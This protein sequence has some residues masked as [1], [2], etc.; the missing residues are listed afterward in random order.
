MKITRW[1]SWVLAAMTAAV[2][3]GLGGCGSASARPVEPRVVTITAVDNAFEA[4]AQVPAGL[5]TIRLVNRGQ[6]LHHVQM[7]KLDEGKTLADFMAALQAGGPPPAWAKDVGG[8]N[9]P[10]PGG[11]E[12]NATLNLAPG[13]YVL[14][15]FIDMPGGVPHVMKGMI[16]GLT[17]TPSDA[18]AAEPTGDVTMRLTDYAFGLS[19]PLAAGKQTIVVENGAAQPH[20]VFI[21]QL[22]PG[23]TLEDLMTW[24]REPN[25]PPPASAVG[26][27]TGIAPGAKN[28]IDVDLAPGSYVLLCFVPDAGDGKPHVQHGMMQTIEVK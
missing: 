27:V 14:L 4:P 19:K 12:S 24:L 3:V 2:T 18:P 5:T 21:G 28:A 15:C 17:V 16:R 26:G 20:E 23:K 13:E 25:G 11:G 10:N 1:N 7:V 8:P 6:T 22:A 9:A